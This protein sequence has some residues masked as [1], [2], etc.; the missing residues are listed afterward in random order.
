M[1]DSV[2]AILSNLR[3]VLGADAFNDALTKLDVSIP[4]VAKKERKPHAVDPE[5]SAKRSADMA[6]LQSY[7]KSIRTE[8]PAE[9]PFKEVQKAAGVRWKALSAEERLKWAPTD[10]TT[11]TFT[12]AVS[13][14]AKAAT[15]KAVKE[16][17]EDDKKG[18][19]RPKKDAAA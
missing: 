8:F 14:S 16:V 13:D 9:T 19:G 17:K 5:K 2:V 18:R 7:I 4:V 12:V 6:A 10:D 11:R 15:V 3:A 1:S